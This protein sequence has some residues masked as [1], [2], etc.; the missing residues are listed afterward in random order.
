MEK[1]MQRTVNAVAAIV[2]TDGDTYTES[3]GLQ[4]CLKC[5]TARECVVEVF[6]TVRTVP[7]MC[8]C[9]MEAY[10]REEEASRQNQR[11]LEIKRYREMGFSEKEMEAWTF[12]AD[13]GGTPELTRAMKAYVD[14]FREMQK[15]GKGLL[16]YGPVGTGK[17][18]LAACIVNALIDKGYPCLMTNFSRL[19]NTINGMWEGKQEY[20]DSLTRFSL[21]AI[22]DLGVER[23]TEYM[24]ESVTTIIDS[25]YRAKVPVVITSNYTPRQLTEE[26]EIRRSRVYDRL[27]ERCL[28]VKVVGASRRKQKGRDDFNGM[29]AL[30]GLGGKQ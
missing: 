7:C 14:N 12:A 13:D 19:T 16:L 25:L 18:F 21:I 3:D 28:P 2:P 24:N 22:D 8:E 26:S 20:I 29:M 6:G 27:L 30:L 10:E 5:H 11:R 15:E 17:S 1:L 4:Y 23:D 9:L